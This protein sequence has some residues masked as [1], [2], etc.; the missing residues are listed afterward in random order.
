MEC[1]MIYCAKI[2]YLEIPI[3]CASYNHSSYKG[4]WQISLKTL[5]KKAVYK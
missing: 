3:I 1:L 2:L 4:L 5:F